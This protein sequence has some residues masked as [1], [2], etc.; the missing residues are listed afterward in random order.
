M[1]LTAVPFT[2]PIGNLSTQTDPTVAWQVDTGAYDLLIGGHGYRLATTTQNPYQRGTEETT[3]HRFD[4]SLEPG[5]QTLAPLPWVKSQ[6]SFHAGA[7]QLN[8]EQGFT[9]FQYQQ[10][11]IEHIRYDNSYGVNPWTP[12]KVS[13]LPD[14]RLYAFAHDSTRLCTAMVSGIDYAVIGGA[15]SLY[16]LAWSAGPDA[17]PTATVIDLSGASFGGVANCTVQSLTS[18]GAKWYGYIK[19]TS[20]VT[21]NFAYIVSGSVESTAAPTILYNVTTNV[22]GKVAWVKERLVAGV[23]A[24]MYDLGGGTSGLTLPTTPN[25]THPSSGW[26]WVGFAEGPQSVLG[27]G[28]INGRA[29]VLQFTLSSTGSVPTLTGGESQVELPLGETITAIKGV[30]SS[31]LALGTSKG[32][33]I[34]S[35]NAYTGAVDMGPLSVATTNPVLSVT[36]RDRFIYGGFTNGQADGSSGL[37]CVDYSMV[38]DAAG[39]LAF[40]P[41]LRPPSSASVRTGS[42]TGC[43]VLP[44]SGRLIFCTPQG[45]HVEGNG[46]GTDGDAWLRTSR[47]RYDTAESK[48]FKLGRIRGALD[49]GSI[50]V[51]GI[52]PFQSSSNL[53][54]FGFLT[55]GDPGEFR[56]PNTLSEW[57]QLEFHLTG[58]A[59]VFNSYQ[60]KALPAP[61][62]QEIIA[63]TLLCFES[64]LDRFGMECIDPETP[65]ERWANIRDL[66]ISGQEVKLVE[67]TNA[68]P[69]TQMVR[70]DQT[71]FSQ[72]SAP[73]ISN[74]FGGTITVKLRATEGS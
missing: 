73:N 72:E 54:T 27:A 32:L 31:F 48:L 22:S 16:Q 20:A 63:L 7:G 9:A 53:G 70:I 14:T 23:G 5:E 47:I 52:M 19:L 57:V 43:A 61:K 4:S 58:S 68:G 38:V 39:R 40:A 10:E 44:G 66:A 12:G 60:V 62:P 55:D 11:Q 71:A 30:I 37:V 69:M 56:L 65:R 35:F 46:P 41:D 28:N 59:C 26:S 6:S 17:D 1:P 24:S 3:S 8:L 51:I 21:G 49:V 13:R 50:G 25:Y 42:V 64:E 34:G 67:F 33:R 74:S 18:D 29:S 2:I 45:V 36:T 15:G